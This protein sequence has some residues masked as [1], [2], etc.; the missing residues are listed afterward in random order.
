M[1]FAQFY[2]MD[3][4]YWLAVEHTA[5]LLAL[6]DP[7]EGARMQA[8]ADAYRRDIVA[9]LD[10]SIAL[11]PVVAVRDGTYRSFIPHSP[12]V[13]G[14]ATRAWGWQRCQGHVSAIYWDAGLVQ[15]PLISPGGLLSL[16]DP[17]TQGFLDVLEDRLLLENKK[18]NARTNPYDPDKDWFANASWQYQCGFER[19]PNI[20]LEADDVPNFI[21]SMLNQYAV[22]LLPDDGYIFREHT[23]GGPPDKIF[24]ESCFLERFRNM[25][26][27]DEGDSL[28][29][30]RGTPRVW[31]EQGEKI[32]VRNAP[33]HFGTVSYEIVSDVDNGKV[34]AMVELPSRSAPESVLLRLRHP[35]VAPIT[36]VEVNHQR[37]NDF[38]R[39]RELVRLDNLTGRVSVQIMY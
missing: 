7:S 21:R 9:S 10:R 23:I 18:V 19:N 20:H 33:T 8:E 32:S 11:T 12:Y 30:A 1:M 4:Y 5:Q 24:E 15:T 29:L 36:S 17:R 37:W 13:R 6:I 16:Q 38:D 34:T 14:C 28:W 35:L 3:A 31:L 22:D 25:L 26:V 2:V 39:D 27:M